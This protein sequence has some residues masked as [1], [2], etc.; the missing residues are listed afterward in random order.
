VEITVRQAIE[1]GAAR[2]N[3]AFLPPAGDAVRNPGARAARSQRL[4]AEV[5]LRHVL[6]C[7]LAALITHP[8]RVLS[9][10]ESTQ[11]DALLKRRIVAEPIQY[12]TGEQEFFG[13]TMKVTPDVLIPRPETEHV[14]EALLHRVNR[15]D[16]LH[17]LDVGTGSGAIAVALAHALPNAA[18][19]AVDLSQAALDVARENAMRHGVSDR[20]RLL[21]SDLIAGVRGELFDAV[22]S[23]P[24]YIADTEDLEPQVRDYE[25]H[26]ALYAGPTGLEIYRRLIPEAHLALKPG[27]WLLLEI[28]YGQ[29]LPLSELLNSWEDVAFV[30]DLQGIPRVAIARRSRRA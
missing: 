12:I 14:V 18:V 15:E 22:I 25:P 20:V 1:D 28:G 16:A 5:L 2:L 9:P 30:D 24:P 26:R 27:G 19:T 7:D 11:Y 21:Q 6:G 3:A 10:A 13:L 8:E 4:D 17:L 23:N 29:K